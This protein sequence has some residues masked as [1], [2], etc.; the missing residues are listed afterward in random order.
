[1]STTTMTMMM[2]RTMIATTVTATTM[3][4]I[5]MTAITMTA[6]IMARSITGC[7]PDKKRNYMETSQPGIMPRDIGRAR[8]NRKWAIDVV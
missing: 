1:M 8:G 4:A 7:H 3:I 6:T 2:I 5:T